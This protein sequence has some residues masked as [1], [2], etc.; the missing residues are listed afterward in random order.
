MSGGGV[1]NTT[2]PYFRFSCSM[3]C[4]RFKPQIYPTVFHTPLV[5]DINKIILVFI[6]FLFFL[7]L[8]KNLPTFK[9]TS[10]IEISSDTNSAQAGSR[11]K[12]TK[13]TKIDCSLSKTIQSYEL[14]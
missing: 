10:L 9:R 6:C 11:L 8:I 1:W 2:A 4:V 5:L 12:L 3:K 13:R 14:L 7:R